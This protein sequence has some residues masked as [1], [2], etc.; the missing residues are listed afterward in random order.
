M[1]TTAALDVQVAEAV[2]AGISAATFSAPYA[3]ISA[4][5]E[6]D[7]DY[8]GL[9]MLQLQ[10]SVLCVGS[11]AEK[12]THG[13]DTFDYQVGVVLAQHAPKQADRNALRLLRQE[14]LDLIRSE[15]IEMPSEVRPI[16]FE[17]GD[18]YSPDALTGR[19]IF[20]AKIMAEYR[21]SRDKIRPPEEE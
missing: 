16:R 10:C 20:Q 1:P 6:D 2:A 4:V 9:D 13:S 8:E 3:K 18:N 12:R 19:N 7:P 21:A 14:V 5:A 11:S 17:T 15:L